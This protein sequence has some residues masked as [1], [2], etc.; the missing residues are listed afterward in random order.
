[1]T[2]ILFPVGRLV[3]GTV[4]ELKEVE[5]SKGNAKVGKDG[6]TLM[7]CYFSVAVQKTQADW[8]MEPWGQTINQVAVGA[9]PG[10]QHAWPH[11]AWKVIDG[12]SAIPNRKGKAPKDQQGFAGNWVIKL[13]GGFL[14][15]LVTRDGSQRLPVD[16]K[17]EL[18][19]YVQA[20][21]Y[22]TGNSSTESPGVYLNHRAV[23]FVG[24]GERITY[25]RDFSSVG[26]GQAPTPAGVMA[27]PP[28]GLTTAPAALAAPALAAP[29]PLPAA[30]T[31]PVA[32][33]PNPA[34]LQAP[35]AAP[36]A[37]APL[38]P[39]PAKQMT[40]AATGTYEAY[41]ASG[42]TDALLVQ[43]GLMVA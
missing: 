18:G 22:V 33:P 12:D 21:G 8:K 16:Q 20:L 23:A 7:Q 9:F 15:N 27:A 36:V 3:Q 17:I 26:F 19:D 2:D 10:G 24:Y 40:A 11:F 35:V 42:W 30:P 34:V 28:A 25:E 29:A 32:V 43:H 41:L 6:K 38:P 39:A 37:P 13:S 31:A 4:H 14:P 5:D 1:M